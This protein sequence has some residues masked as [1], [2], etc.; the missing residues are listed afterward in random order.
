MLAPDDVDAGG[1]GVHAIGEVAGT[2]DVGVAS[3]TEDI[4]HTAAGEVLGEHHSVPQEDLVG[5]YGQRTVR[6]RPQHQT[7]GV[8]R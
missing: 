7:Q 8:A 1:L 2:D 3:G 6:R 5:I 4:A